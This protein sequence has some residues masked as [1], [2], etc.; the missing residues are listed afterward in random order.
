MG[1][2]VC[3]V[4]VMAAL[5]GPGY[6]RF[7]CA[8]EV[9]LRLPWFI[10]NTIVHEQGQRFVRSFNCALERD[11]ADLCLPKENLAVLSIQGVV[12]DDTVPGGWKIRQIVKVH[13]GRRFADQ[14]VVIFED[15]GGLEFSGEDGAPPP[16]DVIDR[17]LLFAREISPGEG[18]TSAK[19]RKPM[20]AKAPVLDRSDDPCAKLS[21]AELGKRLGGLEAAQ[22]EELESRGELFSVNEA[23]T[24]KYPAFQASPAV[25]RGAISAVLKALQTRGQNI[26]PEPFF[27]SMN[28]DLDKLSPVEVL[29]G[30]LFRRRSVHEDVPALL[31]SSVEDRVQLVVFAAEAYAS[32]L[33]GS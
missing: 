27:V 21:A 31:A 16:T 9:T 20:R 14:E 24:R 19:K 15:E 5:A 8:V 13:R 11:V 28:V 18:V 32:A 30:G 12:P 17:R 33:W 2:Q 1:R 4:P 10:V 3:E 6:A 25:P 22:V 26:A 29:L 23:G 7:Y